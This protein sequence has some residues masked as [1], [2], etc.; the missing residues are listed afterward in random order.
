MSTAQKKTY[1]IVITKGDD[2]GFVGRCDELHAN[3]EGET[4]GKVMENIKEAMEAS[5]E[6]LGITTNFNMFVI[7]NN[8]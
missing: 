3:S 8:V 7:K 1:S 6:A 5:A 4:F 2:S